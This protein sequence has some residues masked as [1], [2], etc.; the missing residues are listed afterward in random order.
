MTADRPICSD[1]RRKIS[2]IGSLMDHLGPQQ[3]ASGAPSTS[4]RLY[5]SIYDGGACHNCSAIICLKCLRRTGNRCPKCYG[6]VYPLNASRLTQIRKSDQRF[7]Y[8]YWRSRYV[9]NR[10]AITL[11]VL[12]ILVGLLIRYRRQIELQHVFVAAFWLVLLPLI[13][14]WAIRDFD[15]TSRK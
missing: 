12:A 7:F 2:P 9:M 4:S 10:I 8:P 5:E 3:F 14:W 15:K 11:G 6:G 1:C 13:C